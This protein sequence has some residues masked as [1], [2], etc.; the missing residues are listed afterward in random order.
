MW[1][2]SL[3]VG[4]ES[5]RL[6]LTHS[7]AGFCPRFVAAKEWPLSVGR[8]LE[9]QLCQWEREHDMELHGLVCD[10][11]GTRFCPLEWPPVVVDDEQANS[12]T[13]FWQTLT[14][15]PQWHRGIVLAMLGAHQRQGSPWR[16]DPESWVLTW[17]HRRLMEVEAFL[18]GDDECRLERIESAAE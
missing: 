12:M 16:D 2:A 17:L 10:L 3:D 5:V 15:S 11:D 7:E 9:L 6:V 1:Q 4:P 14:L 13:S 8:A 18:Y